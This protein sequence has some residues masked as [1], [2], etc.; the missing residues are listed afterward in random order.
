[1]LESSSRHGRHKTIACQS[2]GVPEM[3]QHRPLVRRAVAVLAL[4]LF[5]TWTSPTTAQDSRPVS[6]PAAAV[7]GPL[8]NIPQTWNNC[9]PSSVAEVLG[10]WGINRTQDQVK[11]VLRADGN[12]H[13]MSPYGVP[14][15]ARGLGLRSLLGIAGNERLIKLLVSQGFPVIVS[16]FVS[17]ADH[18][19][20]YRPIQAY[21]DHTGEFVSSDPY[22]GQNHAISYAEFDAIWKSTNRRFMVLYPATKQAL[23]DRVL[24]TAGWNQRKAYA[25]DL[26]RVRGQLAGTVAD[27]T[28]YGSH[29]N[30]QLAI[31]WDELELGDKAA[32]RQA[33]A[34]A[35]RAGANPTVLGWVT[36]ELA[37][38]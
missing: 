38:A 33:I 8:I 37:R 21:D 14:A 19:G 1:M 32:A 26:S 3:S 28:G 17:L 16:Q 2:M 36:A 18:V 13:G 15:Y 25:A 35:T 12:L 34:L 5:A 6:L 4:C 10:Y 23:L 24:S 7:L 9:G 27:T 22:L 11:A 20:H 31:A 29:R 30:Y